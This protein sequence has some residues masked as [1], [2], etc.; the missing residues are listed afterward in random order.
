MIAHLE[1]HARGGQP[2]EFLKP[3]IS[4]REA[5]ELYRRLAGEVEARNAQSRLYES[6][7]QRQR[8]SPL[9]TEEKDIPR[10]QQIIRFRPR[11]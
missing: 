11:D 10:D 8:K 3:G 9:R 6:E 7:L 1:G 5:K 2:L 4:W